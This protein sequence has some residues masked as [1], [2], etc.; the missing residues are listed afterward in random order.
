LDRRLIEETLTRLRPQMLRFA[1]LQLRSDAAAEDMVQET[2]VAA[3]ENAASFEGAAAAQTWVFAILKNRITDEF[4]RRVRR[5]SSESVELPDE[6]ESG[7]GEFDAL[8]DQR[9]HWRE[10]PPAWAAPERSLEQQQ[11][12]DIFQLCLDGLPEKPGRVF[13]MREFLELSTEDIC[14]ELEISSSNCW[15]LLHRARLGLRECLS[16][17]WFGEQR[18]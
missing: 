8:F 5:P 11:F 10:P 3:L 15:V 4:R 7:Q 1:R 9:G 2:L 17:R 14:K 18:K 13:M 12:W 6:E 16:Q